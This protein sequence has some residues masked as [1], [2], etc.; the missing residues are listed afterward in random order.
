M[1][2][3]ENPDGKHI[4]QAPSCS[5]RRAGHHLH[6]ALSPVVT[7]V[8]PGP[9]RPWPGLLAGYSTGAAACIASSAAAAG[10]LCSLCD[11]EPRTARLSRHQA[12]HLC[13]ATSRAERQGPCVPRRP[14]LP[15]GSVL[16]ALLSVPELA[17]A[18]AL[19]YPSPAAGSLELELHVGAAQ[20]A[21]C[22][23]IA[24]QSLRRLGRFLQGI[25]HRRIEHSTLP[26]L[27]LDGP[28]FMGWGSAVSE[29][30][31]PQKQ[32]N[33]PLPPLPTS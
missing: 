12:N 15:R 22:T 33:V 31:S 25:Q 6:G 5:C 16:L 24:A 8:T 9:T 7:P 21:V 19:P 17:H 20:T 10:A 26:F 23:N 28:P 13:T 14:A 11:T 32:V 27:P 18:P 1:P 3:P 2:Q 4:A 29:P 30:S